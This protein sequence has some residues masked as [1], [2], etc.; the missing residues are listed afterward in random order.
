MKNV[1]A[2]LRSELDEDELALLDQAEENPFVG[3]KWFYVVIGLGV[4]AAG[5]FIWSYTVDGYIKSG[6][7]S[8]LGSSPVINPNIAAGLIDLGI[9]GAMLGVGWYVRKY[10]T[11]GKYAAAAVM[12][13]GGGVMA[14]GVSDIIAGLQQTFASP[15]LEFGPHQRI[16][17]PNTGRGY[18]RGSMMV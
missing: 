9:G 8:L 11:A 13:F 16:T 10:Q 5:F 6:M 18:S 2:Q 4:A 3:S 7:S 15:A 17:S 1:L 12:G 14:N